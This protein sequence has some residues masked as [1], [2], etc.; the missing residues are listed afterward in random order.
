MSSHFT[1]SIKTLKKD[2]PGSPTIPDKSLLS[3]FSKEFEK[4]CV[5]GLV[6]NLNYLTLYKEFDYNPDNK[7]EGVLIGG[8]VYNLLII[9][10]NV[11][12]L[13][14]L[15]GVELDNFW[16]DFVELYVKGGDSAVGYSPE[17]LSIVYKLKQKLAYNK[18]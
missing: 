5:R 1:E 18:E 3:N 16:D 17:S 14:L 11:I 9:L 6:S 10:Y 13:S 8:I 2:I 4:D 7:E 15:F 12:S